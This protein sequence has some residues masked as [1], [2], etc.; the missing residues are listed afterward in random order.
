MFAIDKLLPSMVKIVD[1]DQKII[2]GSG[3]LIRP[4]G[5]LITCHHVICWLDELNVSYNGD[6][7][8]AE[9][10]ED[11]SDP[12]VDIAVLKIGI[13]DGEPVDIIDPRDFST[14]VFVC[15]FPY[16]ESDDFPDG[17]D[18]LPQYASPCAR[19]TTLR[20]YG[21]QKTH[22]D[23]PWNRLPQKDSKFYPFRLPQ[24]LNPG[25]SGGPVFS[26]KLGGAIAIIQSN[27][28]DKSYAIR[29]TNITEI[30]ERL[31]FSP[32][33]NGKY[34][35][36]DSTEL[37]NDK[38]ESSTSIE[39]LIFSIEK[40]AIYNKYLVENTILDYAMKIFS[41]LPIENQ[42]EDTKKLELDSK[43][44]KFAMDELRNLSVSYSDHRFA[45]IYEKLDGDSKSMIEVTLSMCRRYIGFFSSNEMA[46]NKA[47]YR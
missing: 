8:E 18:S 33:K 7:F 14:E 32:D 23:N 36:S 25:F 16:S 40:R 24:K 9:W 35:L 26:E 12:D 43:T 10:C 19:L 11:L 38:I 37:S 30:L 4:D 29:W 6:L 2:A 21:Q 22:H 31:K 41:A 46:R 34:V 13:E 15:G 47:M 1:P 20:T 5:Y 44:A 3:F 42:Y 45:H 28:G 27:K 17:F 39:E